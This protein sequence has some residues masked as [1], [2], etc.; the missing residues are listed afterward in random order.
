MRSDDPN[1]T[2]SHPSPPLHPAHIHA[3]HAHLT[4]PPPQDENPNPIPSPT[5]NL[6]KLKPFAMLFTLSHLIPSNGA[7]WGGV[8]AG[9]VCGDI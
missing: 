7:G 9:G 3:R 6:A 8:P 2:L 5:P 1:P 4:P